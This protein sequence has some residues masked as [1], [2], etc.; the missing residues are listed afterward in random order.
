MRGT[1]LFAA[2]TAAVLATALLAAAGPGVSRGTYPDKPPLKH[3]GG[4]G[5]PTCRQCHLGAEPN[6]PGGALSITGVPDV[7]RPGETY[8]LTVRVARAEMVVGGFQ[9]AARFA[10]GAAAG[11][12]AGTLRAVD[13][14]AQVARDTASGVRYASQT[15]PGAEQTAHWAAEWSLDWTAPASAAGPVVFHLA[16]NAGNGDESALGDFVYWREAIAG[17]AGP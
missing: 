16:A 8:R 11:R 2:G 5:E 7:Y 9:L 4:F 15:R 10:D 12:Q 17:A 14:R 6:S 3:T 1:R 13:G